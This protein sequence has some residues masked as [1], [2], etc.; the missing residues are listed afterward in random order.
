[1]GF[2]LHEGKRCVE[3]FSPW[4]FWWHLSIWCLDPW[5]L[6]WLVTLRLSVAM[7]WWIKLFYSFL[8]KI[9]AVSDLWLVGLFSFPETSQCRA[10]RHFSWG[11][12]VHDSPRDWDPGVILFHYEPTP[13]LFNA[14][15]FWML[16]ENTVKVMVW[17][18]FDVLQKPDFPLICMKS[19]CSIALRRWIFVPVGYNS[20]HNLWVMGNV[21]QN[22]DLEEKG[23]ELV[24]KN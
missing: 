1:M 9:L 7:S 8:M 10:T 17:K 6:S 11:T 24:W 23:E 14:T 19:L 4:A 3:L 12:G 16:V 18:D 20:R 21:G 22:M 2:D 13:V 15:K 5:S